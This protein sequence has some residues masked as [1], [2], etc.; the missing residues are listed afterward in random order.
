M[1]E[2]SIFSFLK[3]K[4]SIESFG[5][6]ESKRI[7]ITGQNEN[8]DDISDKR[9]TTEKEKINE[10]INEKIGEKISEKIN[11]SEKKLNSTNVA[12]Y[13]ETRD[14]LCIAK[15]VT[16][17]DVE[18]VLEGDGQPDS[19][20]TCNYNSENNDNVDY[21]GNDDNILLLSTPAVTITT[22][23]RTA[24]TTA[25]TTILINVILLIS[26]VK[27]YHSISLPPYVRSPLF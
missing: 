2:I 14:E 5:A 22:M 12:D 18:F 9:T 1:K 10:K 6:N 19:R 16:W 20:Q 25:T 26:T 11:K 3:L 23:T 21:S 15:P 7:V 4:L 27:F 17:L 8:D 24:T 13:D